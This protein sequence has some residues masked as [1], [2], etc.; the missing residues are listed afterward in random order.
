MTGIERLAAGSRAEFTTDYY[1]VDAGPRVL[2]LNFKVLTAR[3]PEREPVFAGVV[4]SL[5]I[6]G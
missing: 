6:G 1:L 5:A 3:Y 4:D 2:S